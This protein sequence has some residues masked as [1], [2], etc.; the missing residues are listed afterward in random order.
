[1]NEIECFESGWAKGFDEGYSQALWDAKSAKEK[2][3]HCEMVKR[4]MKYIENGGY[5][6]E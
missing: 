4:E 5:Y 3:E 1:M 6:D 2:K